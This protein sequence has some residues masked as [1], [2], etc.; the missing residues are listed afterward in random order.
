MTRARHRLFV[1][2]DH[3][4]FN[5]AHMTVFPDG[6]KERLHGHNFQVSVAVDLA[7]VSLQHLLDLGLV[8]AA[9]EAQCRAWN[10][11]LLLAERCPFFQVVGREGGELTFTL[12]GKRYVVP[13]EDVLLLPIDNVIVETLAEELCKGM[14]ARLGQALRPGIALAIEVEVTESPGQGA[15]HRLELARP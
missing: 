6:T 7:D 14:V 13:E 1:G 15:V 10:E 12:C 2:K 3:H 9:L 11:R 8:K 5:A 4:K